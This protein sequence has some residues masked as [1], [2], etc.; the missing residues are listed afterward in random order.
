MNT[1][2]KKFS[3]TPCQTATPLDSNPNHIPLWFSLA[4]KTWRSQ[5]GPILTV[6]SDEKVDHLFQS[7]GEVRCVCTMGGKQALHTR[8]LRDY[9]LADKAFPGGQHNTPQSKVPVNSNSK[10]REPP[11]NES[12]CI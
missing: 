7:S 11:R 6:A 12:V 2:W 1:T 10:V 9:R 8:A 4:Y 3:S 5:L